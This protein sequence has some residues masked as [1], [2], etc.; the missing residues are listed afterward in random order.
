[1]NKIAVFGG[2]G[3][4]ASLIKSQKNKNNYKY[5]FFSRKKNT[6]NNINNLLLRNN[7]NK[8]KNYDVAIHLLGANQ[9]QLKQNKNLIK[10]KNII[11]SRICDLCLAND[12]KLIYISSMQIYK[13][14][15]KNNITMNSKINLKSPYSRSHYDSENIILRKFSTKKNRFTIL[16]LGNV[17]GLKRFNDKRDI[18]SNLVHSFCNMA[19]KKKKILINEGS[20]TRTFV[21]SSVFV[22]LINF[23][24]KKN[25]YKN[26]IINVFYQNLSLS[27]VAKII[28]NRY[29]LIFNLDIDILIEKQST[30]KKFKIYTDKIFKFYP[31][32]KKIYDEID[33]ILNLIKK[34]SKV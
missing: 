22:N 33:Q 2:T 25:Y 18:E 30:K 23:L 9:N 6:K 29:K 24:I 14:Y 16:R 17:F 4:L 12:I 13:D 27:E 10:R 19:K 32:K 28:K 20:V 8:F 11:T 5:I 31:T 26:S 34:K 1:M 21:P 7:F 3:Y 15:G